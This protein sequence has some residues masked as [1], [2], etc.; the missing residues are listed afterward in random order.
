MN[1]KYESLALMYLQSQDVSTLT[2]EEFVDKFNEV[3]A[4]MKQYGDSKNAPKYNRL[5]GSF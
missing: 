4:K 5:S 1:D 3:Y 2:P